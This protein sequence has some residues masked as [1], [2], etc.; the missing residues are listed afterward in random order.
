MIKLNLITAAA[1]GR[2]QKL[3]A[4]CGIALATGSALLSI[5]LSLWSPVLI[6]QS[7][8]A[9]PPVEVRHWV[10]WDS[11]TIVVVRETLRSH[12]T[13]S[14]ASP[15]SADDDAR[16]TVQSNLSQLTSTRRAG[17]IWHRSGA[18][19]L[20]GL[21]DRALWYSCRAVGLPFWTFLLIAGALVLPD[22]IRKR[23]QRDAGRKSGTSRTSLI[24][25]DAAAS[26]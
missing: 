1:S 4:L 11:G 22:C 21:G 2:P 25:V 17:F 3:S 12:Q 24:S 19:R 5:G 23:T 18:E 14:T 16:T 20:S 7:H 6:T 26:R 8:T 13:A 15:W 9:I 10:A